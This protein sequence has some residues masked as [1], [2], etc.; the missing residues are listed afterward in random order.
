M[1][2]F[3]PE[4][5]YYITHIN[6]L[7]SILEKGILSHEKIEQLKLEYTSIY[8][9]EVISRRKNKLTPRGKSL[10]HY[11]NLYFQPRNSMLFKVVHDSQIREENLVVIGVSNKVLREHSV[12]ITDGNAANYPTQFYSCAEGLVMLKHQWPIIQRETWNE[13]IGTKRKMM[14]ECLVPVQVKPDRFCSLHVANIVAKHQ[15]TRIVS[16]RRISIIQERHMF[17]KFDINDGW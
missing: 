8:N 7:R 17:F 11:V 10:W 14:A 12:L 2:S 6:N 4:E 5:L 1:R 13:G 16:K 9:D 15:A 3:P